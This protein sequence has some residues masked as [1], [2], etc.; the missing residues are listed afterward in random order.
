MDFISAFLQMVAKKN[1]LSDCTLESVWSV[2][3]V[4][5]CEK[6]HNFCLP[7]WAT[8]NVLAKLK[9]LMDFSFIFQFGIHE[10]VKKARLQGGLLVNK[11]LK[12]MMAKADNSTYDLKL[13]AY[14][15][16]EN[17]LGALQIALN[18]YNGQQAPY[19]SCQIFE[20]FEEDTRDF[21]VQMYFR[22]QSGETP[23]PVSLLGCA[24]V[25]SLEDFQDLLQPVITQ[26]WGAEWQDIHFSKRKKSKGVM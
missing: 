7:T 25:C 2:Y 8:T 6:M 14:S 26:D 22:N 19:A 11:I 1:G 18:V 16:H 10:R 15:T 3:D 20:L 9:K 12:N 4:L 23:Y 21:T 17:T 5:F 13:V 24:H